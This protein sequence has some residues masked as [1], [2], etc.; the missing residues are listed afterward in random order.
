MNFD[1]GYTIHDQKLE[2][3]FDDERFVTVDEIVFKVNEKYGNLVTAKKINSFTYTVIPK[4][5][6]ILMKLT[7][8]GDD[9]FNAEVD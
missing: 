8:V 7:V 3:E 1:T 4:F 6:K 9:E 2:I 5:E